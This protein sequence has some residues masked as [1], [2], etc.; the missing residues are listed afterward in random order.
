MAAEDE[1]AAPFVVLGLKE[2]D[3]GFA[4]EKGRASCVL[5]CEMDEWALLSALL[6]LP[7]VGQ[8]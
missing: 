4:S 6:L 7:T 2:M 1:K 3:D 5:A 8:A